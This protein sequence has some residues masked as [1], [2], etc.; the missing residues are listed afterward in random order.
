MKLVSGFFVSKTMLALMVASLEFF[1]SSWAHFDAYLIVEV[2][3][4]Y[5]NKS[6]LIVRLRRSI[7]G[8]SSGLHICNRAGV[9]P[10]P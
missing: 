10:L 2:L 4:I 7:G 1:K 5:Y 8:M 3:I 6:M 9:G